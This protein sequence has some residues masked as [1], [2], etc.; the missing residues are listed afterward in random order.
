MTI[1]DVKAFDPQVA[2]VAITST[3]PHGSALPYG[4]DFYIGDGIARRAVERANEQGG[5]VLMLPSLP[6]GN[7]VNFK[8]FHFAC[9]VSVRT[10]MDIVRDIIE[11]LEQDGIRKIVLINAHGGNTDTLR[12]AL[13]EH[14]DRTPGSNRK[15]FVC[16]VHGSGFASPDAY[17]L[18]DHPSDHAGEG[19]TS[20]IM[21]LRP[22]LVREDK[23]RDQPRCE[24]AVECLHDPRVTFVRPWHKYVP[25]SGGGD[26]RTSSAAKG[27]AIIESAADNLA[28]FLV[29]LSAAP[30]SDD[31]PY[32]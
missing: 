3:E 19:E 22:E 31:F 4:T 8:A 24:P 2:V 9:R 21:Y 26:N 13:R 12:A 6:I 20:D 25:Q 15:A 17:A 10:L 18:I 28:T 1:D 29:E 23:L 5:R 32:G 11:A 16:M 30:W 27:E 7:N 14:H